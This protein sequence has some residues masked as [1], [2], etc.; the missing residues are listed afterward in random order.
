[1]DFPERRKAQQFSARLPVTVKYTQAGHYEFTGVSRDV[2]A[3]GIFLHTDSKIEEGAQVEVMLTLP[4]KK[5]EQNTVQ[6]RGTVVRVER[7]SPPGIAIKF[8]KLVI[9]P[10]YLQG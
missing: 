1:M 8:E 4:A 9:L 2:S 3:S 5:S 7:S 6:V 10:E